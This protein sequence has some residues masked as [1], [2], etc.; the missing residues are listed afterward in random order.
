MK[1]F[2]RS[3]TQE[4]I[5]AWERNNLEQSD[6]KR[7]GCDAYSGYWTNESRLEIYGYC[8]GDLILSAMDTIEEYNAELELTKAFIAENLG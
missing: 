5:W 3:F 8:E 7:I 1:K 6:W 2:T 4:N